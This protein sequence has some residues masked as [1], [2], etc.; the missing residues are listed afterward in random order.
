[1]WHFEGMFSGHD[2]G[3]ISAG[4]TRRIGDANFSI[5][6]TIA[7]RAF[8]AQLIPEIG[9]DATSITRLRVDGMAGSHE[10]PLGYGLSVDRID[11]TSPATFVRARINGGDG[12]LYFANTIAMRLSNQPL[13]ATGY[14]QLRKPFGS[15][16]GRLDVSYGLGIERPLQS[17]RLSFDRSISPDYRV[18]FGTD[19][20]AA[21]RGSFAGTGT[22]YRLLGPLEIGV[23]LSLDSNGALKA[24]LLL[25][26][27]LEGEDA[28]HS[29]AL[30]KP[31]ASQAGSAAVRV[32][33]DRNYNGIFDEGDVLLPNIGL[34][35]DGRIALAKTGNKGTCFVDRL[36]SNQE[37][38]LTLNEDSFEDPSWAS[39]TSGVVVIPRAGR[40]VHLDIGV[41]ESAEIEGKAEDFASSREGLTAELVNYLGKVAHTSVLDADGTYV[42]SR[43]DVE[44]QSCGAR[45][46]R[47]APGALMK[48][49]D[50]KVILP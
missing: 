23:G 37:A 2:G 18:R 8:G 47:V 43:V 15:F 3:A 41:I 34:R 35:V 27:G 28:M 12:H 24:N 29:L 17:A 9:S 21:R 20:D 33:L 26:V 30:A 36:V 6:H 48:D 19:Y 40:V 16:L 49:I 38:V 45:A 11:G 25:S 31:G 22:L 32:Y 5:E 13:D 46:V 39:A 1:L 10:H 4:L 14:L 50:V 7:S 44:G 42:F